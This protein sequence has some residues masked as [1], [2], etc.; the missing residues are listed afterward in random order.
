MPALRANR[1]VTGVG[2]DLAAFHVGDTTTDISI[3]HNG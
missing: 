2:G 1:M 3:I